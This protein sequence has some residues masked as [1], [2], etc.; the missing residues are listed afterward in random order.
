MGKGGITVIPFLDLN[1]NGKKDAGEPRAFG[2]KLRGNGG[3]IEQ[4][5]R[6]TT[7]RITDLEPYINYI[8]ELDPA[9]FENVSWQISKRNY[10]IAIDPNKLKIIE[11]PVVVSDEVSGKVSIK[12]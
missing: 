1:N 11:V 8:V 6:D 7:I 10:S 4:N 9:S 2:L 3:R 12:S 5:N